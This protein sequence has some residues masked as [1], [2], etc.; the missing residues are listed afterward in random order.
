MRL[1][2]ASAAMA[3]EAEPRT[4]VR[5]GW[6]LGDGLYLQAVV[7][8]L[9]GKGHRVEACSEWPD[10]FRPLAHA[11]VV[12]P[13]RRERVDIVAHYTTRKNIE[14]TTQFQDCCIMAGIEEPVELKLDWEPINGRLVRQ[15]QSVEKP[16]ILVQLPRTPMGR[17]DGFAREV[18]PDCTTIQKVIDHIGE[19]AFFIQVGSGEALFEFQGIDL[20]LASKTSVTDLLDVA[21]AADGMLGYCSF[22]VP[23]AESLDK[24]ALFVWSR[25]G[26]RS[27]N[28]FIKAITPR[29]ILHGAQSSFIFDDANKDTIEQAADALLEQAG[30]QR[31]VQGPVGGDSGIGAGS[32]QE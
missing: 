17:T 3:Q 29:K 14:D 11:V 24:P 6:G 30:S 26:T 2:E 18:L 28:R 16:V 21:F 32:A 5:S 22:A 20:D 25:R 27:R 15:I 12:S 31:A 13:F 9:V 19:R 8:Y 23:L 10:L 7:R 4:R 1:V